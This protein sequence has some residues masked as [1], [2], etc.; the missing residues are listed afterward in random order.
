MTDIKHVLIGSIGVDSGQIIIS[1]PANMQ[2]FCRKPGFGYSEVADASLA[3]GGVVGEFDHIPGVGLAVA[4]ATA[5]GDGIYPVY[6]VV[7]DG[8]LIGLF[9][10]LES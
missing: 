4:T 7:E 2:D 6:Q 1:D 8:R 5:Q 9:I 10:D 3:G